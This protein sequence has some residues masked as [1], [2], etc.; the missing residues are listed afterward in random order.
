MPVLIYV[1]NGV[2]F[3]LVKSNSTSFAQ[4][5]CNKAQCS[6]E[7]LL[8]QERQTEQ[9]HIEKIPK[10]HSAVLSDVC[11]WSTLVDKNRNTV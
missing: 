9:Y 4:T 11:V 10:R 1:V 5:F 6:G 2:R 3:L 8:S 7:I